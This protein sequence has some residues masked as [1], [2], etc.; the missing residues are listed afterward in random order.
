MVADGGEEF[1][2]CKCA[3]GDQDDVAVGEPAADLQGGLDEPNQSS[4][5]GA[6]VAGWKRF[7]GASSVRNGSAMMRPAHGTCTSGMAKASAGRWL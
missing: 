3:V 5:L 2:G 7:E 1:D 6:C 4:V